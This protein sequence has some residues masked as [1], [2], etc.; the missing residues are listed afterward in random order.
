MALRAS[1][2]RLSKLRHACELAKLKA[3]QP[4]LDV[5]TRWNSTFEMIERAVYLRTA[6]ESV[7]SLDKDLAQKVNLADEEWNLLSQIS[8]LLLT[9]AAVSRKMEGSK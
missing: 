4:V 2:Q 7:L 5:V 8:E 1:P 6:L 9:F 3:L